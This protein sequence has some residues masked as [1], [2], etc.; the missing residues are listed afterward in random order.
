MEV[1]WKRIDIFYSSILQSRYFVRL[2]AKR[3]DSNAPR[4]PQMNK[5]P[6]GHKIFQWLDEKRFVTRSATNL[7]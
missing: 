2:E 1:R 3:I 5:Q 4:T 7:I 6:P